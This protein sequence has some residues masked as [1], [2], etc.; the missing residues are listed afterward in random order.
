[1]FSG[2]SLENFRGKIVITIGFLDERVSCGVELKYG[3]RKAEDV[4]HLMDLNYHKKYSDIN[5]LLESHLVILE[6][7]VVEHHHA[8]DGSVIRF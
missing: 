1:M 3:G 8:P 4:G 5:N 7:R 2:L 6:E